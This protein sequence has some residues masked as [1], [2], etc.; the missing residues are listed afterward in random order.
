[1]NKFR[2]TLSV[3]AKDAEEAGAFVGTLGAPKHLQWDEPLHCETLEVQLL[4]E[5]EVERSAE[6]EAAVEAITEHIQR[7]REDPEFMARLEKLTGED[8]LVR[9]LLRDGATT[10]LG[11]PRFY[12]FIVHGGDRHERLT[13]HASTDP[14]YIAQLACEDFGGRPNGPASFEDA[15]FNLTHRAP[16]LTYSIPDLS[17][18]S[19]GF[20]SGAVPNT[21]IL[22]LALRGTEEQAIT[23]RN[24]VERHQRNSSSGLSPDEARA[25]TYSVIEQPAH[26]EAAM[27]AVCP[28][29]LSEDVE[30]PRSSKSG[31]WRCGNC[32]ARFGAPVEASS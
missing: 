4:E 1:M 18:S 16:G 12:F 23:L 8:D 3:E 21:K 6:E 11:G 14:R 10:D 15:V 31:D 13:I 30:E 26:S 2:V 5:P 19:V 27:I 28:K 32:G 20:H 22:T 7:R 25:R 17:T 29:C 9:E 24:L